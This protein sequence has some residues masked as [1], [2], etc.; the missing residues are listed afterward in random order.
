MPRAWELAYQ[1]ARKPELTRRYTK[2]ALIQEIKRRIL[3]D[4]SHGL[5]LEGAAWLAMGRH[6]A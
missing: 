4:V 2:V 1:I 5:M 3:A 6:S